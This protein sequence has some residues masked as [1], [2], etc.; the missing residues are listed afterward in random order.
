MGGKFGELSICESFGD[1][2]FGEFNESLDD[3]RYLTGLVHVV[4]LIFPHLFRALQ[5][6]QFQ[7]ALLLMQ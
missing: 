3:V 7:Q 6:C 4:S 5:L 1:E 2:K